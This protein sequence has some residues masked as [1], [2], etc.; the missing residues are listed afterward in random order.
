MRVFQPVSNRLRPTIFQLNF[1]N[2][3]MPVKKGKSGRITRA[4]KA[5]EPQLVEG[6]KRLLLVRGPATS[7]LATAAAKDLILLKKPDV[8]VL[9]RKNDIRPFEDVSSLEFLCDKNESGAFI[10]VSHNKKR[11]HN[12]VIGRMFDGHILDMLELGITAYQ[13]LTDFDG[14]KKALGSYPCIS[15]VGEEWDNSGDHK[16]L[17]Q[18]LLD[19][20][21]A[22][23]V[24]GVSLQGLDHVLLVAAS[25]ASIFF[26]GYSMTFMRADGRIPRVELTA[27][28]PHMDLAIR[29]VQH[30]SA[31][32][33][34]EAMRI[35]AQ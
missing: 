32:L 21:A 33:E 9:N 5:R 13:G 25:G 23:D 20:F 1:H 8:K 12:L 15:F 18:M 28:G 34:K 6:P 24:S 19:V 16:L 26:R 30:A 17:R 27:M 10:Y 31:S 4:L 3:E 11:P 7:E 14:P 22:R 35:P 2:A 29:R